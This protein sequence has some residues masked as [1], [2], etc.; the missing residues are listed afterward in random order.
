MPTI[1]LKATERCNSNCKYCDVIKKQ[2]PV[3]MSFE[4]LEHVYHRFSEFFSK[5][6]EERLEIIWHGGEPLLA[7]LEFYDRAVA[8]HEKYLSASAAKV[9]YAMQTNLTLLDPQLVEALK[10]FNLDVLGTSFDPIEGIRGF[11]TECDS[12]TYNQQFKHGLLLLA[13]NKIGW[14]FIYVVHKKSLNDPIGLFRTLV[15]MKPDGGFMF[16]PVL[17]YGDDTDGLAVSPQ[18][19]SDFLGTIFSEWWPN[20]HR[21]PNVEPFAGFLR[22]YTNIH[23]PLTC[24]HSGNCANSHLYIGP[25]GITAHCGRAADWGLLTYGNIK[26]N[27]LRH[28]LNNELRVVMAQRVVKLGTSS[29]C[30]K[31]SYWRICHGGCPL[32]ALHAHGDIH[33]K[34]PWCDFL[35]SFLSIY[36]EKITGLRLSD[37]KSSATDTRG[38]HEH[39]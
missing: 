30:V 31:C 4:V 26:E 21:Y 38:F 3:T 12:E 2:A 20:R 25:T 1:I 23:S 28:L 36:F 8:L 27:S 17:V 14:G 15:N 7:G 33:K 13:K 5:E 24:V 16:N 22:S 6:P 34:S 10:G 29:D 18:E 37:E 39:C 19:Y 35:Q 32:D 9:S 11:G